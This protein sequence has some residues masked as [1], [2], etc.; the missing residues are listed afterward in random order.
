LA[1]RKYWNTVALLESEK[2]NNDS[3]LA[4]IGQYPAPDSNFMNL[5]LQAN[6]YYKADRLEDAIKLYEKLLIKHDAYRVW[7][8]SFSVLLHYWAGIAYEKAHLNEQAIEQYKT[9][10]DI[11]KNAD[12]GI[13]E[14]ED[15]KIRLKRLTI[16]T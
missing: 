16:Q 2:G 5:L 8:T 1:L 9:F 12:P 14:V 3:A 11:W 6:I 15:A 4:I 13:E 7:N 10:L